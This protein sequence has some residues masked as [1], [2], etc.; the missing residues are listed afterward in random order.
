MLAWLTG[1]DSEERI[2]RWQ[3]DDELNRGK[4]DAELT[5]LTGTPVL[6]PENRA[7]VDAIKASVGNR[8]PLPPL[9]E[10]AEA[11]DRDWQARFQFSVPG[12][13]EH[14][15]LYSLRAAYSTLYRLASSV[16]HPTIAGLNFVSTRAGGHTVTQIEPTT[17][18]APTFGL[19]VALL[20][21]A[22][23]ISADVLGFPRPQEVT[24]VFD[25]APSPQTPPSD[26]SN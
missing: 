22:L 18:V 7:R 23:Y 9:T 5:K 6:S 10:R 17:E 26:P 8:S 19:M 2:A 15:P 20:G 11:A 3:A 24:D 14:H 12:T 1:A 13:T 4:I 25:S 21:T 16:A